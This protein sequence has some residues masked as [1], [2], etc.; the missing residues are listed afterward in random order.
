M[1]ILVLMAGRGKRFSDKGYSVPKPMIEVNGKPILQWTT[2]SCPYIRHDGKGQDKDINLHFAVLQEHLDNGLAKFLH[3]VYGK[4]IEIVAFDKVTKGS[5]DTAYQVCKRMLNK[6]EDLLVLDS[7]NKYNDNGLKQFISSLP[8]RKKTMAIACWNPTEKTLPNKWSN[9]KLE[10]GRAH[11][12][13]EKDDSWVDYPALIGIFYFGST[14]FFMNYASYIITYV[15]PITFN[16]NKEYYMSM[17]PSY[18][19]SVGEFLHAHTVT[20]VVP[21]GTPEDMEKFVI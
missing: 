13:R 2:E 7:D 10:N 21:L 8:K 3:S 16:N 6:D 19:I 11:G 15:T 1:N 17:V 20:D 14:S 12:I 18:I 9:A 5:L 4:N